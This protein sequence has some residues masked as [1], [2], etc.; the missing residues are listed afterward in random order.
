MNT[1][2]P[3]PMA[4]P[5][6]RLILHLV[7]VAADRGWPRSRLDFEITRGVRALAGRISRRASA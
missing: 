7:L 1:D 3:F 2:A 4:E 5:F 6:G